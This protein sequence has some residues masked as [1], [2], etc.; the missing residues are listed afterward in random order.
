L[1]I[2]GKSAKGRNYLRGGW[3]AGPR[4][5]RASQRKG[6]LRGRGRRGEEEVEEQLPSGKTRNK[7]QAA[8]CPV[9]AAGA[10]TK[11][12]PFFFLP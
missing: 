10:P 12:P 2:K 9:Q 1:R 3:G 8:G 5:M 6:P 11:H 7:N 4:D